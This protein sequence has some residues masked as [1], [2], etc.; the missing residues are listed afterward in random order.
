MFT[1]GFRGSSSDEAGFKFMNHEKLNKRMKKFFIVYSILL[2]LVLI[3]ASTAKASVFSDVNDIRV[4]NGLKPLKY[5][6]QLSL[7]GAYHGMDF[8]EKDYYSHITPEGYNLNHFLNQTSYHTTLG[9]RVGE[10]LSRDF[11]NKEAVEAWMIS[12]EHKVNILDSRYTETG[13]ALIHGTQHYY[14]IQV[15]GDCND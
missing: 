11:S 6:Y 12:P 1:R 3:M 14:I 7:L 15:F 13:I 8:L 5:N 4:E 9:C 2:A 10:N